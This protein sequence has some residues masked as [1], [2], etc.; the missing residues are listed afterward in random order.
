MA[1]ILGPKKCKIIKIGSLDDDGRRNSL[2]V[3]QGTRN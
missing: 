2:E 3:S 1:F